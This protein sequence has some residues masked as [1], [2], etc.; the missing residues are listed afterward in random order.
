MAQT[1]SV[2]L[3]VTE[4][5]STTLTQIRG[6]MTP[7]RRD[8]TELQQEMDTL[9]RTKVTLQ[10]DMERAKRELADAKKAFRDLEDEANSTRLEKAQETYNNLAAQMQEVNKAAKQTT[11]DMEE[12]SGA[13][14]RMDNR[15]GSSVAGGGSESGMLGTLAKAGLFNQISQALSGAGSALIS[16]T[17]GSETGS[18]INAMLS[19]TA[20]GAAIGSMILPG[21]GTVVGAGVGALAGGITGAT[22]VYQQRDEAFKG[23]VQERYEG[24]T[25]AQDAS[26]ASGSA[27]A[28]QRE[29]DLRGLTSLFGGDKDAAAE[30]QQQLIELGRTPPFSYSTALSL[31]REMLGLGLSRDESLGRIGSLSN[32]AAALDLSENNVST[33]VSAL[34]SASLNGKLE[35]RVMRSL[36]KMGINAYDALADEFGLTTDQ[37]SAN[38]SKLDVERAI[39]AIYDYMGTRFS[40]AAAG[41][42]NTYSG[43]QGILESR[44]D[45]MN[46]AYGEGYNATRMAGTQAEIDYLSGETGEAMKVANRYIGQWKASLENL[47]EEMNRDAMSAVMGGGISDN[48]R[49]ESGALTDS[50]KRLA[51]LKDEYAKYIAEAE[52]GNEEAGAEIG[53][54]LAEAQV[55]AQNEYFA[56]EGYQLQLAANKDLADRIKNDTALHDEYWNAGR[57]MGLKF[58]EGLASAIRGTVSDTF[59]PASSYLT[60]GGA[61]AA[62]PYAAGLQANGSHASGLTR[63]PFDNYIALLHEGERVLTAREARQADQGASDGGGVSVTISGNEFTVRTEADIEAIA[64]ALAEKISVARQAGLY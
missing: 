56:S 9:S 52:A 42:T 35:S 14:S 38:L 62:T 25:A 5:M 16:S 11:K 51:E 61:S 55:I 39:G 2:A 7:F 41:L 34:E 47:E 27:I 23:V 4:N 60:G 6:A 64:Q 28:A 59:A 15:A 12:L 44:Q 49:D 13:F 3:R 24:V 45:D 10:V 63:V 26:V 48:F 8:I 18:F 46:A 22:Q 30:Y 57:E 1:A 21:V 37:V 53:K 19:G 17:Y 40:G 50:G 43:T 20:S 32:A 33:I 54:I 58:S 31:S 36:S 29:G